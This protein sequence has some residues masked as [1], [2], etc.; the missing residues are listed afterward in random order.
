MKESIKLY[1]LRPLIKDMNSKSIDKEHYQFIYNNY[2]FD[3]IVSI[4]STNI[5]ILVG[6][7]QENWGCVIETDSSLYAKMSNEDFYSLLAIL[8]LQ[9]GKNKFTSFKFLA[10]LSKNAPTNSRCERVSIK[11]LRSFIKFRKVD[12]ANKVYFVGWNAHLTDGRN[13]RNFDKTEYF[14]GKQIAN[15]CR[16]YNISSI[17]TDIESNANEYHSPSKVVKF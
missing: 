8:R 17:W 13:A 10:L 15:Y 1:S 12:E 3:V 4:N 9:P 6:I 14:F 7:H 11:Q 5:E 16:K 2:T